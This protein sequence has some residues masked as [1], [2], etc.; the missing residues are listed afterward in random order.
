MINAETVSAD[1][2]RLERARR[3]DAD[4]PT[5]VQ[6]ML[7]DLT[8]VHAPHLYFNRGFGVPL[9][10]WSRHGAKAR[11]VVWSAEI[12][13]ELR[14]FQELLEAYAREFRQSAGERV[15]TASRELC[16]ALAAAI[17]GVRQIAKGDVRRAE[18]A[19]QRASR[20]H[21]LAGRDNHRIMNGVAPAAPDPW[22][23]ETRGSPYRRAWPPHL[24][25]DDV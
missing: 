23:G 14:R 5:V 10:I 25:K 1:D 18:R 20:L 22:T 8:F 12:V 15:T 17:E 24:A 16:E 4:A 6:Q 3:L 2:W 19:W 13:D 11:R 7:F 9:D 21:A